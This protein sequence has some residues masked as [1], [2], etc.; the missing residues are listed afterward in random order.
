[1]IRG[2]LS[3][4]RLWPL[5]AAVR[6][7]ASPVEPRRQ[8]RA[9]RSRQRDFYQ[10]F[11]KEMDLFRQRLKAA[12]PGTDWNPWGISKDLP[13]EWADVVIVGGGIIGWS[14]AFWLK[15][16]EPHRNA[17]R[18]VVVE[19]DLQYTKASTVLSV[20]GIRQQFSLPENIR[21]S[22]FSAEF[23]RTVNDYLGVFNEPPIDIQFN[24][25]GYLFLATEEGA[26]VLEENVQIQRMEGAEV[27]LL[28]P[29]QLKKTFPW[30]NTDGV[31]L[32][33]YGL[34]NEGWFDPWTLLNALRNKAMS[35]GVFQSVGEVTSFQCRSNEM[36]TADGEIVDFPRIMVAN[37]PKLPT[38]IV[39]W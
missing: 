18:V 31:A 7:F 15:M 1:M 14:I 28:S 32:A 34:E 23:L 33:S 11:E 30:V 13:P 21:M 4:G 37:V 3:L 2:R 6:P 35:M 27:S 36:V 39:M 25:S 10:G 38:D 8:F 19:R 12:L 24:P 17:L 22:R 26:A 20:G 5:A 29:T 9:G 16:R